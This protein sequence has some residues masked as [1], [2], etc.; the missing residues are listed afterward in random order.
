MK[1]T[2]K[3]LLLGL[4]GTALLL[5]ACNSESSDNNDALLLSL[6]NQQKDNATY[7]LMNIPYSK[8]YA[9]DAESEF[10][11]VSGATAKAMNGGLT[12]GNYYSQTDSSILKG[13]PQGVTFPVRVTDDSVLEGLTEITD[14][15]ASFDLTIAGKGG[16]T[17]T[18]YSG[19][20]KS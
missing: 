11:S 9:A 5:S 20:Q 19:K 4:A 8:F 15:S 16:S 10:D 13:I 1:K 3:S 12:Y 6:S 2:V 14:D 17:T 7:V 18:R